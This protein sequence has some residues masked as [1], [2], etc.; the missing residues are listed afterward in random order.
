MPAARGLLID[1]VPDITETKVYMLDST[2]KIQLKSQLY[3]EKIQ[4]TIRA[5][6]K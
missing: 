1:G 5:K 6:S 2:E 3:I 4:L